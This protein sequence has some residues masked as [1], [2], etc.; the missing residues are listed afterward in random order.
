MRRPIRNNDS[1]N[2]ANTNLLPHAGKLYALWEAG[3]ATEIDPSSLATREIK[4]WRDDLVKRHEARQD[5]TVD[6]LIGADLLED[7]ARRTSGQDSAQF[8]D[9]ARLLRHEGDEESKVAIALG[10]ELAALRRA[11]IPVE[12][13]NGISSG[14]AAAARRKG[15]SVATSIQFLMAASLTCSAAN[16]FPEQLP[17][18]PDSHGA[19][20]VGRGEASAVGAKG[21]AASRPP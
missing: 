10:E 9:W 2:T 18:G 20:A 1:A 17:D 14:F 4:T 7:A 15:V 16:A 21:E 5:L 13:V 19:V 6:L 3:S 11:S 12:I 8:A